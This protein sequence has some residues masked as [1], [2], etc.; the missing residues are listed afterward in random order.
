MVLSTN[1][2][3]IARNALR[4]KIRKLNKSEKKDL[5]DNIVRKIIFYT[6]ILCILI[7]CIAV[8][9][10]VVLSATLLSGIIN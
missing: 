7:G 2:Y 6:I 4:T 5:Y 8:V 1:F 9:G 10:I 3:K